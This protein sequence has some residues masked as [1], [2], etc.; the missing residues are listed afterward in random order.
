MATVS[1]Y[2]DS[3]EDENK[4]KQIFLNF[5]Y[6]GKR[7]RMATG[8]KINES[9]WDSDKERADPKKYKTNPKG[10]NQF[11]TDL[12]DSIEDITNNNEPLS[13]ADIKAIIDKANGKD[14]N[15]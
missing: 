13:T 4:Q 11:F 15:D 9:K 7:Y 14:A 5:R 3:K 12:S 1:F 10:F 6:Q 8:K 2:L